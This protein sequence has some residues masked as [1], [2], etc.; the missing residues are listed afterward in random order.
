MRGNR[1]PRKS[2]NNVKQQ[3]MKEY[4]EM[5]SKIC[6]RELNLYGKGENSM[7]WIYIFLLMI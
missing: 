3:F 5:D 2:D 6:R 4:F 1:G 7:Q